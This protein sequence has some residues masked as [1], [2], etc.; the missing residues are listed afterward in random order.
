MTFARESK[1]RPVMAA[2]AVKP[3]DGL[4]EVVQHLKEAYH[5]QSIYLF[6]SRARG[7]EG[8]YRDYD[9]LLIVADDVPQERK[10]SRLAYE[11]LKGTPIATDVLVCTRSYFEARRHLRAS[12]PG[13]VLREGRLL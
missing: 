9:L 11:L 13:T 10:S 3:S 4:A 2:E 1:R 12:L 8:S 7:D 6:G 5:P